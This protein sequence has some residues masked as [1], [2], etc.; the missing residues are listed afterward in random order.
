MLQFVGLLNFVLLRVSQCGEGAGVL[1]STFSPRK[2]VYF[3]LSENI[4][5]EFFPFAWAMSLARRQF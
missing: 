3:C 2:L 4:Y 5:I 1:F